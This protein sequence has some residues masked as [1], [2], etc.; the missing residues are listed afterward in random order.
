MT[1][2]KIEAE[3]RVPRARVVGCES[4]GHGTV[5][6]GDDGTSTV[7][8]EDGTTIKTKNER[9]VPE[10]TRDD[11]FV[12]A[13]MRGKFGQNGIEIEQTED[14]DMLEL[15]KEIAEAFFGRDRCCRTT[16]MLPQMRWPRWLL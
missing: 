3:K 5:V 9:L 10:R 13:V 14:A 4:M 2:K 1:D 12:F 16:W 11:R 15:S 6:N 7:T 8:F